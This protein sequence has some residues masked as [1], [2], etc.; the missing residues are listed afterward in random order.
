MDGCY[1]W[2]E[3]VDGQRYIFK[4]F[5]KEDSFAWLAR[6]VDNQGNER[7]SEKFATPS[8]ARAALVHRVPD[9]ARFL[10]GVQGS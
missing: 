10:K 3:H 9:E 6:I 4:G 5:L 1:V 7:W 8:K 2:E